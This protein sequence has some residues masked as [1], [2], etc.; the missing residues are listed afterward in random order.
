MKEIDSTNQAGP[1]LGQRRSRIWS[2][3]RYC[4]HLAS[5]NLS[6]QQLGHLLR[7]ESYHALTPRC[8]FLG[9]I[10]CVEKQNKFIH[11]KYSNPTCLLMQ[12]N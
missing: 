10:A 4:K 1:D 8:A 11:A 5:A 3:R 12:L 7:W 2:S 6:G 9:T